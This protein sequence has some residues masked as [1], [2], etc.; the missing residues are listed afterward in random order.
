MSL[1]KLAEAIA[2]KNDIDP[3]L[4]RNLA[5]GA[6]GIGALALGNKLLQEHMEDTRAVNRRNHAIAASLGLGGLT[7]GALAGIAPQRITHLATAGAAGLGGLGTYLLDS[8]DAIK[9]PYGPM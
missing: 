4:V 3:D 2:A 6:G 7:Y 5:L 1:Q 8:G 9:T